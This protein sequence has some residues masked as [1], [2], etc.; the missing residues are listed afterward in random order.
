VVNLKKLFIGHFG[1]KNKDDWFF[2]WANDKK[3]AIEIIEN[4]FGK[5][6]YI[7]ELSNVSSGG[8]CFKPVDIS[9]N[10]KPYYLME[11]L[12]DDFKFKKDDLIQNIIIKQKNLNDI[13]LN[14]EEYRKLI[15]DDNKKQK[16]LEENEY[17]KIIKKIDSI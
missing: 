17:C 8:L 2:S 7:E 11:T 5:P 6:D 1:D 10:D 13:N 4:I 9:N 15:E 12:P 3:E 14:R 16:E